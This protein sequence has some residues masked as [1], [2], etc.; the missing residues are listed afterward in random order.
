MHDNI[1]LNCSFGA[2]VGKDETESEDQDDTDDEEDETESVQGNYVQYA[3][4]KS[5]KRASR[6]KRGSK[7]PNVPNRM[8]S[9]PQWGWRGA[10]GGN[11]AEDSIKSARSQA[12][13]ELENRRLKRE[14]RLWQE[15]L[16]V[17]PKPRARKNKSGILAKSRKLSV[18]FILASILM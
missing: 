16:K 6:R 5:Q 9:R 2:G 4:P 15:Y 1:F 14:Q 7:K 18:R 8:S 3:Q 12:R 17:M 11:S 13:V 10:A